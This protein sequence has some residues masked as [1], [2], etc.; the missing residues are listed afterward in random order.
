M[1]NKHVHLEML[2]L[3]VSYISFDHHC[4]F[5]ATLSEQTPTAGTKNTHAAGSLAFTPKCRPSGL[6]ISHQ[7]TGFLIQQS[8]V[9]TCLWPYPQATLTLTICPD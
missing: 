6:V 9:Q 7:D 5:V 4:K 8:A 1:T 3:S 2:A